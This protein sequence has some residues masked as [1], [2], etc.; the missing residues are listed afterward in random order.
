VDTA[1]KSSVLFVYYT[2]TQRTC[3]VCDVMAEPDFADEARSFANELADDIDARRT[4]AASNIP[5]LRR[6]V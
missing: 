3:R 5:A 2:H 6:R 4:D 1:I